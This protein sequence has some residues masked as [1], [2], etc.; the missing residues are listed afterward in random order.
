MESPLFYA[1]FLEI[2][3]R[4]WVELKEGQNAQLGRVLLNLHNTVY[5][6]Y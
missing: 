1:L 5:V 4:A 2:L 6:I 3:R